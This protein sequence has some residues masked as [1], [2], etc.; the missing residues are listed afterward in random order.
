MS[1]KSKLTDL[2]PARQKFSKAISLL[3][4][5]MVNA[6][7]FPE[8]RLTVY[9]WDNQVDE[10][11][12]GRLRKGNTKG[13]TLLFHVLPKVCDMNGCPLDK[14]ISSEVLMV[15]M[16]SR[17][18]LR[19][20]VVEFESECPDCQTNHVN[21]LK[22]PD[23]LEKIGAKNSSWPGF[24]LIDLPTVG[25]QIKTR[26]VTLG[27]ELAIIERPEADRGNICSDTIARLVA[28]IASINDGTPD[29]A[30]DVV[31]WFRALCPSDQEYLLEAF[32]KTQPQLGVAVHL[33]C[34]ACGK[35]F[36]HVL[37][38]DNDF[39]RRPGTSSNRGKV[40]DTSGPGVQVKGADARPQQSTGVGVAKAN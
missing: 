12:Q 14:F 40:A 31:N 34:D 26:L 39:F 3:S 37:Q 16:V 6:E 27:E 24:D 21:K 8:G 10:W 38:L 28:G 11:I 25:D 33:K 23:Q 7:Y 20:D 22:V 19:N 36:D 4:G 30:I 15:L 17:S 13:R 29:R 32:D 9:P 18:I 2:R 35:E 5:G 1:F